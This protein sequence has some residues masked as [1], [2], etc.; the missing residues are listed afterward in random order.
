MDEVINYSSTLYS[1]GIKL[2]NLSFAERLN[3]NHI[4][5]DDSFINKITLTAYKPV[6]ISEPLRDGV[7]LDSA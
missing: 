2:R 6:F 3:I 7:P 4:R 1:V 5:L